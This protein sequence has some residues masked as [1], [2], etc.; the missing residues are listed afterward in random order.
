MADDELC[1]DEQLL[2]EDEQSLLDHELAV[3]RAITGCTGV[4]PSAYTGPELNKMGVQ[5][6]VQ[7]P[8]VPGQPSQRKKHINVH[9][10]ATLDMKLKAARE[11]KRRVSL[12][13]GE[14]AVKAA[15]ETAAMA[16]T[17]R[18]V[19]TAAP[20]IVE[21]ELEWLARWHD[22]QLHPELVTL[23]DAQRA[24]AARR[25]SASAFNVLHDTQ[26]LQVRCFALHCYYAR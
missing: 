1:C 8:D 3:L 18:P 22:E 11:A 19:E 9:C 10:N 25:Q 26:W 17:A 24:L 13:V 5:L 20:L 23:D 12:I 14:A 15:E 6:K 2:L 16:A 4:K 21:E 7:P